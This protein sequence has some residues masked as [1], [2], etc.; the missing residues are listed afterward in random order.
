MCTGLDPAAP[1]FA[2]AR[3]RAD[4]RQPVAP[5]TAAAVLR[6]GSTIRGGKRD[7]SPSCPRGPEHP[8]PVLNVRPRLRRRTRSPSQPSPRRSLSPRSLLTRT[9]RPSCLETV[10]VRGPLRGRRSGIWDCRQPGR[11]DAAGTIREAVPCCGPAK[12]SRPCP[13]WSSRSTAATARPTS[14]SCAA[15]TSTTAPT[16]RRS[17]TACRSTC[18]PTATARAISDLNF[19]I[20][21]LVERVDFSKGPYY[22]D[23]GD[24]SSAGAAHIRVRRSTPAG[25][26]QRDAGIVRLPA[27]GCR[28]VA[29]G[30]QRR[31]C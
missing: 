5:S 30:R 25:H 17:S 15:S 23:V 19:L 10:E 1:L 9:S 11:G 20:P 26:R 8:W 6:I 22:A 16:S 14:T 12:R 4:R 7:D 29:P 3:A 28:R 13:A 18:P 27:R 24:F 21:E 31:L 2:L